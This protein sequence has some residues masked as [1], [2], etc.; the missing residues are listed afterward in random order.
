MFGNCFWFIS[1]LIFHKWHI[2]PKL[3]ERARNIIAFSIFPDTV[4]DTN[5][6]TY[7]AYGDLQ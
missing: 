5:Q 3:I 6:Q 1:F 2:K 4:K 7:T